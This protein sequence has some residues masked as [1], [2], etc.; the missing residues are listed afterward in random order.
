LLS[1]KTARIPSVGAS[2]VADTDALKTKFRI[3]F[4]LLD[5]NIVRAFSTLKKGDSG[6]S[7]LFRCLVIRQGWRH[8]QRRPSRSFTRT[9]RIATKATARPPAVPLSR[10][11]IRLMAVLAP[12]R[13]GGVE[14]PRIGR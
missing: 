11:M 1:D 13:V 4:G 3:C 5:R 8:W 6:Q 9:R 12:G 10:L 14:E 7:S 2:Y